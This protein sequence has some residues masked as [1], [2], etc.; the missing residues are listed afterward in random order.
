MKIVWK[1]DISQ[2]FWC[3][4]EEGE[5]KSDWKEN[6][7]RFNQAKIKFGRG[8]ADRP[9]PIS[10]FDK[11]FGT[12]INIQDEAGK[13]LT[14]LLTGP[15]GSGKTTL[16]FE[17]C[18]RL[19]A[20]ELFSLY[21]SLD[22]RADQIIEN[23][24]EFGFDPENKHIKKFDDEKVDTKT[25]F[26]YGSE[27]YKLGDKE[28]ISEMIHKVIDDITEKLPKTNEKLLGPMEQWKEIYSSSR[29]KERFSPK[30]IVVDSLNVAEKK[31]R[32]K[33]FRDFL[34]AIPSKTQMVIFVLDSGYEKK[35]Y[36]FWEYLCDIVI[37]MD[38]TANLDYFIRTIEILKARF[39]QHIWGKHQLKIYPKAEQ[40]KKGEPFNFDIM[41][42]Y[43]PYRTEGGIFIY[44]SLHYYLS[45]YKRIGPT[46]PPTLSETRPQGFN[47]ILYWKEKVGIPEKRS[48][49]D[50]AQNS[51][52]KSQ[53]E[54]TKG[55]PEGRCTAF[56]GCRGG[57]KSHLAY[58][59]ILHRILNHEEIGLI[60]SLRDDEEMTK[61]TLS[62]IVDQEFLEHK[63]TRESLK[64]SNLILKLLKTK[65]YEGKG[66]EFLE[67][68]DVINCLEK[69][70]KL[71]ILYFDP[72]YITPE[73]FY[74][75]IFLSLH[76]LKPKGQLTAL[77]N[78]VDQLSA[79]FPLCGQQEIFLPAI[80]KTFCAEKITGIFIA[81]DDARQPSTQ[82][83][84]LPMADLIVSFYPHRFKYDDYKRH[85]QQER[86]DSIKT[87]PA[88]EEKFHE[89]V[90]I[91]IVRFAGGRKAGIKGLLE[92]VHR[93]ELEQTGYDEAGLHFTK[94][95]PDVDHGE[96]I[97]GDQCR[98]PRL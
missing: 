95:S 93:D 14:I 29:P 7:A 69:L 59:H 76:R 37:R 27:D 36:E 71:E 74:H 40:P 66:F 17:L 84:L 65:K 47:D 23:A 70:N 72:G 91:Q 31:D 24:R 90:V 19:A 54:V 6:I 61:Q 15:P 44:P 46:D 73:E 21:L 9:E 45:A 63:R 39:Q 2:T 96:P 4:W 64:Q 51:I 1:T 80:I 33:Y 62:R 48:V 12:G 77:F 50:S 35:E 85:L 60:I 26:V 81:V 67:A 57:H 32:A 56:I 38:Y 16:A 97:M 78:S 53:W 79:R 58:L 43:H 18:Y 22:T 87:D 68:K 94:L 34:G 98:F 55:I 41:K 20:R 10:W 8:D 82:Y 75:R 89:A 30:I 88:D 86:G 42:R 52:R 13:L 28:E 25:V 83:G 11:L 92:L 3:E 49:S 5:D